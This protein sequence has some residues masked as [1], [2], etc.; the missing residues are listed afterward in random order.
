MWPMY[1]P[2][3]RWRGEEERYG[4]E[5]PRVPMSATGAGGPGRWE[6]RSARHPKWNVSG[7][8]GVLVLQHGIH[9]DAKAALEKLKKRFYQ[10]PADLT[11]RA[12]NTP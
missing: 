10:P 1:T 3:P 11:Y 6:W 8:L 4:R 9:P 12:W 7:T 5:A 2:T